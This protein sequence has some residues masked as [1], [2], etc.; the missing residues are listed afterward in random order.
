MVRGELDRVVQ[1]PGHF[2]VDLVDSGRV[3]ALEVPVVQEER[4]HDATALG[5]GHPCLETAVEIRFMGFQ[6]PSVA[7]VVLPVRMQRLEKAKP[8][9]NHQRQK[10]AHASR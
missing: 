3:V 8:Q 1:I 2:N 5:G 7:L 10:P 6:G 4:T 9:N